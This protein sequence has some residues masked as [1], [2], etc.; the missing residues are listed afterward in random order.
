MQ[1]AVLI[2]TAP[3]VVTVMRVT[4]RQSALAKISMNVWKKVIIANCLLINVRIK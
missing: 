4:R 3:T 2:M 1:V